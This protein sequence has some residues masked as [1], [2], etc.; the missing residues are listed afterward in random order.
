MLSLPTA[1]A[2]SLSSQPPSCTSP[3]SRSPTFPLYFLSCSQSRSSH[4]RC[5]NGRGYGELVQSSATRVRVHPDGHILLHDEKAARA[6]RRR[7]RGLPEAELLHCED[8][9]LHLGVRRVRVLNGFNPHT[10]V[11]FAICDKPLGDPNGISQMQMYNN[12]RCNASQNTFSQIVCCNCESIRSLADGP[13]YFFNVTALSHA[14]YNGGQRQFIF[15]FPLSS[16][17]IL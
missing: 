10:E 17:C 9:L 4:R 6:L 11:A 2:S 13:A 3:S 14:G 8:E 12:N 16:Y 7:R 5:R 15:V 1:H